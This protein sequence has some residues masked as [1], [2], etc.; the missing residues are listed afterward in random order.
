MTTESLPPLPTQQQ[1]IMANLRQGTATAHK[2]LEKSLC[3]K[4]LFANDYQIEE[5]TVLLGYFY[6][7]FAAIEPILF[8]DLPAS[9][10][11]CVK[12][13]QK[14]Q[15]LRKDLEFFDKNTDDLTVCDTLPPMNNFAEKMG[16]LYVLEGSMLGGRMI[17]RHLSKH[18]QTDIQPALNF[19]HCYGEN[20]DKEWQA[21]SAMMNRCFA[22]AESTEHSEILAAA[23]ATFMGLQAWVERCM[24]AEQV[25][26][27]A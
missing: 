4:R 9:Y 10:R 22:D 24:S 13:R 27:A 14:T 12:Y 6:G 15:L 16:V 8:K 18:F 5:Y 11:D 2:Q 7:F 1:S 19:Y 20:L 21:F 3:F 23:N 25:A 26:A 17:G